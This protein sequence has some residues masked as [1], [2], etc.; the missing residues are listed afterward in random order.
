MQ[1]RELLSYAIAQQTSDIH[2]VPGVPPLFRIDGLL[3]PQTHYGVTASEHVQHFVLP[4]LNEAQRARL[5]NEF[6]VDFSLN[7]PE[8]R[9]RGNAFFQRNGLEAVLRLVPAKIPSAEE[10]M[11]PPVIMELTNLRT[12]LVLITGAT[13]SGKSTTLACMIDRINSTRQANIITIEDPIEFTHSN[14]NSS[15]S[16]R[17]VGI[18][19]ENFS[20]ALRFVMRQDPDV[21]M[22]GEMRDLETIAAAITVAE[23][24]HLVF[25]TLHCT[26]ASQAVDRMIDV[27]P[28]QQQ[29]QIRTQL[30]G[31][32]RAVIAQNLVPKSGG[33]GRVAV[34]EIMLINGAISSLIRTG[35][36]HEIS[37]A[38]EM[39]AKEGM[40]SMNRALAELMRKNMIEQQDMS[41]MQSGVH[42]F[43]LK[44]R[45]GDNSGRPA[46]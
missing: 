1:I 46:A 21:V 22:V 25:A 15:V 43:P 40:V 7:L 12:G 26:D 38:I 3:V 20:G 41:D 13:G 8:T 37:S 35:R 31:V 5:A 30:A 39:G 24:G 14:K 19:V 34:R 18:H 2:L 10:L 33:G 45:L 44:R 28:A 23:T 6:C 9:F 32:L 36:T 42:S 4:L 27:F 16:Q 11:L 29:Q 17:E